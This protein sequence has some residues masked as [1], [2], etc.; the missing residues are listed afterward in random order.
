MGRRRGGTIC[1]THDGDLDGLASAALTSLVWRADVVPVGYGEMLAAIKGARGTR[2]IITDLA[3][4]EKFFD[5]LLASLERFEEVVIVDH[6]P[7]GVEERRALEGAGVRLVHDM[8]DCTTVLAYHHLKPQLPAE[9]SRLAAYAALTDYME[10]GP[11]ARP[12]VERFERIT[13]FLEAALYALAII[14]RE[15]SKEG[16]LDI[17]AH[18]R[19]FRR[20]QESGAIVDDALQALARLDRLRH[21]VAK[22]ITRMG[23]VGIVE[24][25][26]DATGTIAALALEVE[27]CPVAVAYKREGDIIKV[28]SRSISSFKVHLGELVARA[29]DSAG[30]VGGGHM[31]ATGARIPQDRLQDFLKTFVSS[32][33]R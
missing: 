15:N 9:A 12:I 26:E 11:L 8:R 16:L 32:L 20:P 7:M 29:A 17:V 10:D 3:L 21:H 1:V 28:S 5:E 23:D 30:G 33:S 24:T 27:D 22:H 19:E 31:H 18:L 6:H 2:L 25:R 4:P 14:R 13:L